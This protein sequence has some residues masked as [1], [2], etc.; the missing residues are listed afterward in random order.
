MK[1]LIALLLAAT[2]LLG[3]CACGGEKI[4]EAY[5]GKYTCYEAE[6]DGTLV[7][8]DLIF[9]DDPCT[10]VL[11]ADGKAQFHVDGEDFDTKFTITDGAIELDDGV[12][13]ITGTIGDG[14][15]ELTMDGVVL[16][17]AK[18]GVEPPVTAAAEPDPAENEPAIEA[19]PTTDDPAALAPSGAA[20]EPISA[21]FGD[22]TVT[23]VG[24]ELCQD[25]DDKPAF[26]VYYEVE[27]TSDILVLP[28]FEITFELT[29]EG[30]ELN[31]ASTPWDNELPYEDNDMLN[32]AP[33]F[34]NRCVEIYSYNDQGGLI[35]VA[36]VG[37]Y[38]DRLEFQVDPA[39]TSGRPADFVYTT[40]T[41]PTV[42]AGLTDTAEVNGAGTIRIDR[43]EWVESNDGA[44]LIRV[45]AEYTNTSDAA[46]NCWANVT[47]YA[48]QDGIELDIGYPPENAPE[49]ENLSVDIE[50]GESIMVAEIFEVRNDSPIEVV[51]MDTW[52]ETG[53]AIM[54]PVE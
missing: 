20:F 43:Y 32:I 45:Y 28:W 21:N 53:A 13:T 17:M 8:A 9:G 19:E 3:L 4:D 49:E 37:Y 47:F 10:I 44:K 39:N 26:A 46:D 33:G 29:Q 30:Y 22:C 35:D 6:A 40:V 2:M 12:E 36:L 14:L 38:G 54:V 34:T 51:F 24:V 42:S 15:L 23:V 7:G 11:N 48:F 1:K 18:E 41:E 31:P 27:N 50:P 16:Y 25:L 52:E 5:L